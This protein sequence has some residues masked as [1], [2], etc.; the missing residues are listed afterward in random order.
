MEHTTYDT[1]YSYRETEIKKY[2]FALHTR[3]YFIT[4]RRLVKRDARCNLYLKLG[5]NN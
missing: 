5:K 4:S 2:V 1:L 3:T